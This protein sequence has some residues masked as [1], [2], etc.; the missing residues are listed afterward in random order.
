MTTTPHPARGLLRD[1]AAPLSL[2]AVLAV[3]VLDVW[4][5]AG[6]TAAIRTGVWTAPPAPS[7]P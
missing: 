5:A 2:L 3:L 1:A 4:L 6:A 7:P